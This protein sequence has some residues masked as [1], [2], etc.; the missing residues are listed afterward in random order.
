MIDHLTGVATGAKEF[1]SSFNDNDTAYLSGML[2]DIGKYSLEFQKRLEGSPEKIDH[3]TA[4]AQVAIER[5]GELW[6][7]LLAYLIVGHHGGMP[8][9]DDGS[10]RCL[11]ARIKKMDLKNFSDWEKEVGPIIK[12]ITPGIR[13]IPDNNLPGFQLTNHIRMLFS[14]LVDSDFLD[15]EKAVAGSQS[16]FRGGFSQL[17]EL[18]VLLERKLRKLSRTAKNSEV[19]RKRSEIL[20]QCLKKSDSD[21]GIFSLTVPTGGGKTL[22]SM[23]FALNHAVKNGM[24]RVIYVIPYTSIIE[25]NAKIFKDIFGDNN[26]LEHHSNFEFDSITDLEDETTDKSNLGIRLATQNWDAPIIVTTNVQFFESFFSNKPSK[27]RKLHNVA[28]SVVILDEAQ[29]LPVDFLKPSVALLG[30][31]SLNYNTS[32]VLCTAT[33]PSLKP[34]LPKNIQV[35]ELIDSP[36][37]FYE[38]FRRVRTEYLGS[39]ELRDDELAARIMQHQQVL[40]I[41]NTR[42][43]AFR[44]FDEIKTLDESDGCFHLSGR[45]CPE[46]RREVLKSIRRRLDSNVECRVISTQLIEAGVDIDFP[47]V[48]RSMTGIDSF[49]QSAG[50][51][52]REGQLKHGTVIAFEPQK[53]GIP[54][55][56]MSLTAAKA[57]SV[58][59]KYPEDPL[60]LNAIYDYFEDLY[61]TQGDQLDSKNILQMHEE[62]ASQ[63]IIQFNEIASKYQLIENGMKTVIVPF[64]SNHSKE[65][66]EQL[67]NGLIKTKFPGSYFKEFQKYAVQVY[68]HEFNLLFEMG[69][70]ECIHEVFNVLVAPEL[71]SNEFGLIIPNQQQISS[72][73]L[74]F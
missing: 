48:Y 3:T 34:Y 24:K 15:T 14:C 27:C 8:D 45:M 52:N 6:G 9:W 20:S 41:V 26:V 16:E 74:L 68:P 70:I 73:V 63:L 59:R 33:Q 22:S 19:N 49:A 10:R 69:A 5:Y 21:Q 55:G 39:K 56:Y 29:M 53:H 7:K 30:E 23:A 42:T 12:N 36:R 50:R 46:H 37:D 54:K 32:I 17:P 38:A 64:E 13:I 66:L 4:G 44:L 51:C 47:V 40:C 61:G 57:R 67:I 72:E 31:L 11:K 60:N 35:K 58:F 18:V 28:N 65:D 62:G 2:H 71:Y 25:Q 1:A 43:H